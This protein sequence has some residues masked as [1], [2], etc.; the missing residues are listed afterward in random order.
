MGGV[1]TFIDIRKYR[2]NNNN[3]RLNVNK[4]VLFLGLIL[5]LCLF[6][7]GSVNATNITVTP[8]NDAI[9]NAITQASAGDTLNLSPGT[10]NE[11]NI[12]IDKNL[13]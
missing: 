2:L 1:K 9:K 6:F 7:A 12:I 5:F 13:F 11:Y 10:Y 3:Y 4:I 8:G